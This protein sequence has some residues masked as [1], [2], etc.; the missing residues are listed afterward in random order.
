MKFG[1]ICE[2]ITD[3]HV[4]KHIIQSFNEQAEFQPI[5]PCLDETHKKT[6]EGMFGGWELVS[7]YLQSD[8]LEDVIVN[9]DYLIIQIDTDIC[10][11]SNFNAAPITLADEDHD[12]LQ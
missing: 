8:N 5:Q 3:F 9:T 10:E 7:A 2:G 12:H 6:S 4:L 11:H 1:I